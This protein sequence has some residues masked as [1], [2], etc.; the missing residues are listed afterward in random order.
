[1]DFAQ[2]DEE[3]RHHTTSEGREDL[4]PSV[5][6]FTIT[7]QPAAEGRWQKN[8]TTDNLQL[9]LGLNA[10]VCGRWEEPELRTKSHSRLLENG[11]E[12]LRFHR[13]LSCKSRGGRLCVKTKLS[14][15][16]S[17]WN[18]ME[19]FSSQAERAPV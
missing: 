2:S 5:R 16:L 10:G 4:P 8:Q 14:L 11:Q 7:A 3:R 19:F 9:P 13:R 1:M 15:Q 6:T 17:V 18:E 12:I